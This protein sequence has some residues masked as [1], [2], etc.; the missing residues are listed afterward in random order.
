MYMFTTRGIFIYGII[1]I[2]II[3]ASAFVLL[4]KA[5][6]VVGDSGERKIVIWKE[7]VP[8]ARKLALMEKHGRRVKDL[9]L[10]HGSVVTVANAAEIDALRNVPEVVSI[11]SDPI[12]YVAVRTERDVYGRGDVRTNARSGGSNTATPQV[13]PWGVDKIDAELIWP[14]G[15][16]ANPIKVGVIDTGISATH[17]DLSANIKGGVNTITSRKSWNDDNGHGSHVAGI[18]AAVNNTQG[19]IGVAP[20]ADLY[21]IKVLNAKGSGYYSD[22]IE[23][24]QWAINNNIQVINMSLGGSADYQPLHDAIVAAHTMGI[25]VVAAA[26]NSSGAVLYPAAYPEVV[27][28]SATDSSNTVAPWSSNGPEVD[29]AAPGVSIYSTYK[30]TGYATLSGTSMATPH[31]VGASAL[32]LNTAVGAHDTNANGRWD[33]SEVRTQLQSTAADLG[34][35]GFDNFYGWGLVSAYAAVQ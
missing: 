18:I 5:S 15:N 31:V 35:N 14:S 9:P 8:E 32:L 2:S 6:I 29:V 23:G 30:G 26:G 1:A 25:V 33:P 34:S 4:A 16:T 12:A 13:L 28:V 3:S 22:I 7:G 17:P 24:I 20:A 27:A 10:V 11:E 19:V 21:A